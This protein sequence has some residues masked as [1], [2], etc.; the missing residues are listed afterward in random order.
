MNTRHASHDDTY[1]LTLSTTV[2]M[3]ASVYIEKT[4]IP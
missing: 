1:L 4:G 3:Y 2:R